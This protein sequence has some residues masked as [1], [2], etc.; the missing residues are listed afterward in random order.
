MVRID[1]GNSAE[2][3]PLG[4]VVGIKCGMVSSDESLAHELD[5]VDALNEE[6]SRVQQHLEAAMVAGSVYL[7]QVAVPS[8][9][10][11]ALDEFYKRPPS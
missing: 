6:D 2:A 3:A 5:W 10:Q 4:A 8:D 11:P 9:V 1:K 7:S